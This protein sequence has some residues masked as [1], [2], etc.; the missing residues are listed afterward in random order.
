M[1]ADAHRCDIDGAAGLLSGGRLKMGGVYIPLPSH[2]WSHSSACVSVV[3]WG[4]AV[5]IADG[6]CA[7]LGHHFALIVRVA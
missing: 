1:R 6:V 7:K 4:E 3:S 5:V 2:W